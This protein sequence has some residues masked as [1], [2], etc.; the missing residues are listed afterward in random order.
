MENLKE[1]LRAQP[2]YQ[3]EQ[4]KQRA[5]DRKKENRKLK[6][7]K[8]RKARRERGRK[9]FDE[10]ISQLPAKIG[11][12]HLDGLNVTKDALVENILK[13]M[14]KVNFLINLIQISFLYFNLYTCNISLHVFIICL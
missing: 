14:L 9:K 2:D 8:L 5:E 4:A 13:E 6:R 12:V 11:E 10:A 3:Q 7:V 1:K